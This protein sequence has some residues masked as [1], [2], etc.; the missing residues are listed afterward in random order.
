MHG[1]CEDCANGVNN[2][3]IGQSEKDEPIRYGG[4]YVVAMAYATTGN[5][6]AIARLKSSK[7]ERQVERGNREKKKLFIINIAR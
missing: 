5:N 6:G 1:G 3:T 7:Q 4:C 2:A